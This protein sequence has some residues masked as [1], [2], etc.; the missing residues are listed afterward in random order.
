MKNELYKNLIDSQDPDQEELDAMWE[1]IS[2]KLGEIKTKQ[3]EETPF[4][5]HVPERKRTRGRSWQYIAA[6]LAVFVLSSALYF[7]F[8]Q[9]GPS[10]THFSVKTRNED[11]IMVRHVTECLKVMAG[12]VK[13]EVANEAGVTASLSQKV[14]DPKFPTL[15]H[16]KAYISE[17]MDAGLLMNSE[18]FQF[19]EKSAVYQEMDDVLFVTDKKQTFP[20]LLTDEITRYSR[21]GDPV[22]ELQLKTDRG[23]QNVILVIEDD[24]LLDVAF[25]RSENMHREPAFWDSDEGKV[26]AKVLQNTD[27]ALHI[28]EGRDRAFRSEDGK[29]IEIHSRKSFTENNVHI[30]ENNNGQW[31]ITE[32]DSYSYYQGLK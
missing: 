20:E 29:R 17:Y 25:T 8:K 14:S 6:V 16:L 7:V 13:S 15:W 10:Q 12:D 2:G 4:T 30:L 3:E 32:T 31:A 1:A 18:L 28:Q 9:P 22:Y 26:V 11:L 23:D 24:R 19:P 27:P 21:E 5:V